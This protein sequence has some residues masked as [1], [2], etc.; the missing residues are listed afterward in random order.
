MTK[1]VEKIGL[2]RL[3]FEIPKVTQYLAF[4]KE[5]LLEYTPG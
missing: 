4:L 5:I 2:Y 1:K 3:F